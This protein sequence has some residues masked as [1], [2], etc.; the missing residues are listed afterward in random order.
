MMSFI[1]AFKDSFNPSQVEVLKQVAS[2]EVHD[3]IKL[4]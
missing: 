1:R 4:I 3:P 2:M